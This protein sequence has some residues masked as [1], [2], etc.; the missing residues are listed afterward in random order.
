MAYLGLIFIDDDIARVVL[1]N[2][3][4]ANTWRA[5][6]QALFGFFA[7]QNHPAIANYSAQVKGNGKRVHA[8]A[9]ISHL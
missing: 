2:A 8:P 9:K 4:G 1:H 7:E 6:N 5:P 3:L